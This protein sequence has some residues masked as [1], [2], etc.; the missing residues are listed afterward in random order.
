MTTTS[1][2]PSLI[3]VGPSSVD[4]EKDQHIHGLA[5]ELE[6]MAE[7]ACREPAEHAYYRPGNTKSIT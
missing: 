2:S 6:V 1:F 3:S 5:A 7:S 4:G